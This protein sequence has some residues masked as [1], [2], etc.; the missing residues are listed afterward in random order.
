MKEGEMLKIKVPGSTANLGPGFDSIG[1]ALS[2]YLI[3][4]VSPS[5]FW[6]FESESPETAGLPE[7]KENLIYQVAVRTASKY[8]AVLPPCHVKVWSDIPVARGLGSS[9]AAIVAGVE[10]ADALGGLS[11]TLMEKAR[12]AS[13][14]EDHPDNAGASV[15]GGLVIGLHQKDETHIVRVPDFKL[16]PVVVIPS[17][18][19]FTKDAREVLPGLLPFKTAV[20]AGAVGNMLVA[21]L[22][23][24]NWPLAGQ[25]MEK[26]LLHQ[27]YRGALTPELELVAA[28]AREAGAYGTALS[29]AGPAVICF[30]KQG[31]GSRIAE[32]LRIQFTAC[33]VDLLYVPAEGSTVERFSSYNHSGSI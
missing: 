19:I 26:D 12:L 21:A 10:L 7:G 28:A 25:M 9:A 31:D 27:P 6:F 8:G 16:E 13:L 32:R 2:R 11:L 15:Y 18:K 20:E 33:Q 17:Y 5:D 1:M 22:M 14:E 29:G 23:T 4:T 24:A 3:L 30:A